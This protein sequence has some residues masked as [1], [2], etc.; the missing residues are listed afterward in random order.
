MKSSFR[1][2]LEELG[3]A[4]KDM[5]SQFFP[6]LKRSALPLVIILIV[7]VPLNHW[8]LFEMNQVSAASVEHRLLTF[9][10]LVTGMLQ[11]LVLNLVL[12]VKAVEQITLSPP[13]AWLKFISQRW[14]FWLRENLRAL[15][16]ILLGL[17]LLILPGL[18]LMVRYSFINF[19]VLFDRDQLRS[20][21]DSLKE[22]ARLVKGWTSVTLFVFLSLGLSLNLIYQFWVAADW[23]TKPMGFPWGAQILPRMALELTSVAVMLAGQLFLLSLF[24]SRRGR[25]ELLNISTQGEK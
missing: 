2:H 8:L 6:V 17:I 3:Q 9:A 20:Q 7:F 10:F 22:S 12:A 25:G 15:T 23:E 24:R 11:G 14:K 16:R 18:Y 5:G 13:T 1:Q 21:G 4:F 19:I